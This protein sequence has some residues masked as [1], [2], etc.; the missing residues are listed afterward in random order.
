[1][2][3]NPDDASTWTV[4]YNRERGRETER[5]RYRERWGSR[6]AYLVGAKRKRRE[7]GVSF[8]FHMQGGTKGQD[9]KINT[10]EFQNNFSLLSQAPLP[11]LS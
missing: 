10:T 9:Q 2:I 5:G 7:K 6:R 3:H 4:Y 1:M 8:S 11:L